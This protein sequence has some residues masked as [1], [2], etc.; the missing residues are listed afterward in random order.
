[1]NDKDSI[2]RRWLALWNGDLRQIEAL[3][4]D[5]V[6]LHAALIGQPAQGPM[7]GREALRGW[8]ASFQTM[9]PAVR[10]SV[11][12]GPLVDGDMVVVRWRAQGP[13]GAA[14]MDFTGTDIL[15]ILDGTIAEYW[16]TADTLLM[17]QQAGM[18]PRG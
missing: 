14:R 5:G 8:I 12:V 2:V 7:A 9:L 16:L 17:M 11:E 10:F 18:L 3:V 6:V 1:M 4:A 13:H 15:R